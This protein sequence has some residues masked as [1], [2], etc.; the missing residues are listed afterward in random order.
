MSS[1]TGFDYM[2]LHYIES[3]QFFLQSSDFFINLSDEKRMWLARW[4][5]GKLSLKLQR[6]SLPLP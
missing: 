1:V 3:Y 4:D 5:G 6:V 2:M